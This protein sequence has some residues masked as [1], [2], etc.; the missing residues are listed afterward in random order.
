MKRGK[1]TA[2]KPMRTSFKNSFQFHREMYERRLQRIQ[3]RSGKTEREVVE[4]ANDP[5]LFR[6]NPRPEPPCD[7]PKK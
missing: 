3:Q 6:R 7:T 4:N 2:M 1:A 5:T